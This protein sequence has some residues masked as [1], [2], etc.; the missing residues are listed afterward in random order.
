M[1]RWPRSGGGPQLA[2][3]GV[4]TYSLRHAGL[5]RGILVPAG[6]GPTRATAP[7]VLALFAALRG[8]C[9]TPTDPAV[10]EKDE[11]D[12]LPAGRVFGRA[13]RCRRPQG[14]DMPW[15]AS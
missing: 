3:Q 12:F 5:L 14:R 6:G 1:S 9:K 7:L 10:R 13:H 15:G 4:L 11:K 2:R 8:H